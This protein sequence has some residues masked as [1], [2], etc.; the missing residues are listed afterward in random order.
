MSL[1][2]CCY[3]ECRYAEHRYAECRYADCHCVEI[4]S[5]FAPDFVNFIEKKLEIIWIL[6][7]IKLDQ[8]FLLLLKAR[9]KESNVIKRSL[10]KITEFLAQKTKFT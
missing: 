3:A 8:T 9:L 10:A 5:L 6:S 2:E 7:I 1:S 4:L